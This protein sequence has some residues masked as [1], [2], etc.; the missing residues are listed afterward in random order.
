MAEVGLSDFDRIVLASSSGG[1]QAGLA[2]GAASRKSKTQ[3]MGISVDETKESL[4]E[5]VSGLTRACGRELGVKFQLSPEEVVVC[6][7]YAEPGY[8]VLTPAEREAI[9]LF[10]QK[11]GILLDPVYTGRAAAGLVDLVRRGEIRPGERILFW[12]TGGAPALFPYAAELS[13]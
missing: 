12:H 4:Q 11:E 8:A 1:T 10:A 5:I 13:S 7:D 3:I 6:A 2:F 9:E